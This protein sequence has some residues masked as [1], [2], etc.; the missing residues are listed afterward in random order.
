MNSVLGI[1]AESV[2]A[3]VEILLLPSL[4]LAFFVAELTPSY[5]LIGLVP[6]LAASLWTLGRA[7]AHLLTATRRRR[8]PWIFAAAVV[9]AA[10]I[11]ILAI[12]ALRADPLSLA[13][14]GRPL[15][16]TFFLC[17][18]VFAFAGGFGSVPAAALLRRSIG[19]ESWE[20]FARWRAAWTAGLCLLAAL[21]IARVLGSNALGF[22]NNY[23]RLF[24]VAA[25]CLIAVAVFFAAMRETPVSGGSV[26][27]PA[28]AP[29]A[30][31][32]PLRDARFRRFLLFRTLLTSTAAI[33][34]F[35]ILYAVTR[36]GAPTTAIGEFAI[37]G[38]LGWLISAPLWALGERR[39]G[40]RAVLQGA[41][42]VRLIAPA[43]ALVLPAVA[44]TGAI[45][46]R[47]PAGTITSLFGI[48]FFTIGAAL[49]GQAR[50]NHDYLAPL[51]P[52]HLLSTYSTL[53][54]A[55]LVLFAF[56][57]VVG[58]ALIQRAGY[59]ALFG[60]AL[61]L[62]LLAV[63]AGG[64]LAN[65]PSPARDRLDHPQSERRALPAPP[66]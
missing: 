5:V 66:A 46:E 42:V 62:G 30:L 29:R 22:P 60:T 58:G 23:G 8:Q 9:R 21:L 3:A 61:V 45:G 27:L 41:A 18:I 32:Q 2:N 10:A 19:G 48:A 36:L 12:V 64:W 44:A 39:S 24:L 16:G 55:V 14:A 47:M 63:F 13:R 4:I 59:E 53:T 38:V 40:P 49:A 1:G 65:I 56:A 7:P 15:L 35:L 26:A 28:F 34:P 25:I 54:N 52:P 57:P 31:R 51:A 43:I 33:D 11:L 50:A 6:A 37:A 17:L 20:A